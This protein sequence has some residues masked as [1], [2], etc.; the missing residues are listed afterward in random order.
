MFHLDQ[1]YRYE[2]SP[3]VLVLN[4]Y[5]APLG[6]TSGYA[7]IFPSV[8]NGPHARCQKCFNWNLSFADNV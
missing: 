3:V 5:H 6:N 1:N 7:N 2:Y 4:S 8:S